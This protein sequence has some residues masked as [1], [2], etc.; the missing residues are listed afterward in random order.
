MKERCDHTNDWDARRDRIIGLGEHS[1][2]KSYYPELR[3]QLAELERFRALLDQSQDAILLGQLPS[4]QVVDANIAACR[5]FGYLRRDLLGRSVKDIVPGDV[6]AQISRELSSRLPSEAQRRT[7][8]TEISIPEGVCVPVEMTLQS[9]IFSDAVYV[10]IV[11]RDITERKRAED[12]LRSHQE[13][14]E[15]L[16]AE[17]TTELASA[18]KA[19]EMADQAKSA[20]LANMSHE[21]RTPLNVVMGFSQ[22]MRNDP[23]LNEKQ[24]EGLD[25]INRNGTH[26]L[27]LINE[28]LEISRIEAGRVALITEDFD[29]WDT[30]ENIRKMMISRADAKGLQFLLDR[31]DSVPRYARTDERKFKQVVINLTG[32]AI[33]FTQTGTVA[34]RFRWLDEQSRLHCEVEDTGPGIRADDIPKLFGRFVQVGENREGT[35]LGLYISQK[36]TELMGGQITVQSVLG[37]GSLFAFDICCESA[38]SA[39]VAPTT[40]HRV[41]GLAPG[42]LPQ[43]ILVAED[44]R[45]S[46]LFMVETLRLAGFEVIEAENGREAVRLFEEFRP[47]LILMD[48]KMPVLNGYEA[49][50]RIRLI[51]QEKKTPII[52]VTASVFEEERQKILAA[53]ADNFISKPVQMDELYD[54]IRDSLGISYIYS[55]ENLDVSKAPDPMELRDKIARLPEDLSHQLAHSLTALDITGFHEL[56]PKVA[57]HDSALAEQL[58]RLADGFQM[59]ELAK[60]FR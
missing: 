31:D 40:A 2:R 28:V 36:I 5:L 23:T 57:E 8:T 47:N 18:K 15:E 54:K 16:V 17:R 42:Q 33:K 52:A 29:L 35:G 38:S 56:L 3:Q 22:L 55:D 37:K 53:G 39:R 46:R 7:I 13:H 41:T 44:I 45:E 4:L 32:N 34:V 12:A 49:I 11:A 9:V 51:P 6:Y 27:G 10:V 43:R 50:Q 24:R 60:L 48:M 21:L 59:M 58:K 25:I 19:A 14:L 26:L 20:F 30:I 1:I